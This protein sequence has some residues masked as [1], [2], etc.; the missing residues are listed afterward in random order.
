MA[1]PPMITASHGNARPKPMSGWVSV[2]G[3]TIA[4]TARY[5]ASA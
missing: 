1:W 2:A 4:T 3:E 5:L